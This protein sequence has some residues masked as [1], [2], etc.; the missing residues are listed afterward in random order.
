MDRVWVYWSGGQPEVLIRDHATHPRN[1]VKV[2]SFFVRVS[3]EAVIAVALRIDYAGAAVASRGRAAC[4]TSAVCVAVT[5]DQVYD[6]I[7]CLGMAALGDC[8]DVVAEL[9]IWVGR[10]YFLAL[11][12]LDDVDDV[13]AGRFNFRFQYGFQ[14]FVPER[15]VLYVGTVRRDP[16]EAGAVPYPA[17]FRGQ[18]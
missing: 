5:M 18:R 4:R 6:V 12:D 9:A 7:R 17:I 16:D 11:Y 8:P 15:A 13:C 2:R 1:D 10:G 3:A 14:V